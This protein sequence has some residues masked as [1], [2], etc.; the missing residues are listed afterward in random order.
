MIPEIMALLL[1]YDMSSSYLLQS[2][3]KESD[4]LPSACLG[5]ADQICALQ[6]R[7]N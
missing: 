3:Y 1:G 6:G 7:W 5:F 4:G 2:W